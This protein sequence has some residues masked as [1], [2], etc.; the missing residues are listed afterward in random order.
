MT[1]I[2][3]NKLVRDRIPDIIR[4]N[5]QECTTSILDDERFVA[6]LMK[7]LVEESRELQDAETREKIIEE[8]ADVLEVQSVLLSALGIEQSD[9]ETVRRRK[10]ERNG[11]FAD[12]IFLHTVT[13]K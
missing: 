12:K 3:H 11:G 1:E 4:A 9:I 2:T 5:G 8:L 13:E 10:A 7:K 6:E